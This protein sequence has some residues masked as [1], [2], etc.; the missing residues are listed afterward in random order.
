MGGR[1]SK[2]TL[3][4]CHFALFC[5]GKQT[6]K[7][8]TTAAIVKSKLRPLKSHSH[9]HTQHLTYKKKGI[10]NVLE[11]QRG[12]KEWH[13]GRFSLPKQ[14]ISPKPIFM[15]VLSTSL[16]IFAFREQLM[17]QLIAHLLNAT[18]AAAAFSAFYHFLV[19]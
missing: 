9:T 14:G 3:S 6:N 4:T 19:S 12:V 17:R 1:H 8:T 16:L 15:L 2:R 5:E 7:Q 11:K 13:R 10:E 18:A